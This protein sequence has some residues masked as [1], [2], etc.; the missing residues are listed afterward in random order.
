[1]A[2]TADAPGNPYAGAVEQLRAAAKWMIAAF[3]GVGSALIAGTQLKS[4]AG[5]TGTPLIETCVSIGVGLIGVAAAIF[6]T[7]N[8]LM[9][10]SASTG[11]LAAELEFKPVRDVVQRDDSLLRG[12]ADDLPALINEM[13]I[14]LETANGAY[15]AM[16]ADPNDQ[17]LR[18][19]YDTAEKH[20][21]L[22]EETV[23]DLVDYGIFLQ[24]RK[25]FETARRVMALGAL[26]AAAGAI[27]FV[28]FANPTAAKSKAP[29]VRPAITSVP[30]TRLDLTTDGRQ[31]LRGALGR[32]CRLGLVRVAVI[33][34]TI[35][36][37]EILTF[38]RPG[39]RARILTLTPALGAT[40]SH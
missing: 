19:A 20:R 36:S 37:P 12:L 38:S 33:G 4:L 23:G 25:R 29:M 9:P 32:R 8:V 24:V 11:A 39:C 34:G 18:D 13:G 27:G 22:V 16:A 5:V 1:V 2:D 35:S 10:I 3:G 15:A 26:F 7:S 40:V 31:V 6:V 21:Q 30:M 14:S 28:H 17:H